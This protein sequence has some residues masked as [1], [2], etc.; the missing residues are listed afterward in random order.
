MAAVPCRGVGQARCPRRA[1]ERVQ[2]GR[3]E[4]EDVH[5][6]QERVWEE[7]VD[8]HQPR[9]RGEQHMGHR[10]QPPSLDRVGN[11]SADDRE[12][13]DRDQRR[14]AQQPDRERRSGD[15][16][17]LVRDRDRD[18]LVTEVGHAV[19][20]EEQAEVAR[21]LERRD[22]HQVPAAR[23]RTPRRGGGSGRGVMGSWS[24]VEDR[25]TEPQAFSAADARVAD[26]PGSCRR[27]GRSG[28]T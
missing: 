6:P 28:S 19:P 20:E 24:T 8:R 17:D 15:L 1:V 10:D 5:R 22:I 7:R 21:D 14:Q 4:R 23:C 2:A 26:P 25:S 12:H 11:R 9:K 18:D 27:S 3:D 16:E 13:E